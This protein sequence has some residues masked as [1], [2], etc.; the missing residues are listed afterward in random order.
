MASG[1][2][3]NKRG[4]DV[5]PEDVEIF[6]HFTASRTSSGDAELIQLDPNLV[7]IPTENPNNPSSVNTEIFGGLY[8]LKLPTTTFTDKG[9][10]TVIIKPKE[11]RTTIQSCG[12]L[13]AYP[14]VRGIVFDIDTISV[15]DRSVFFNNNLIGYRVEYINQTPINNERKKQNYFTIITSNNFGVFTHNNDADVIN[16]SQRFVFDDTSSLTFCTLT[17]SSSP[18]VRPNVLPEIGNPGQEVIITNT[19]FDPITI[20]IEMVDHDIETLAYA[21]YGNQT[22]SLEDGIYTVYN[23]DNQIYFQADLYEIKEE[24]NG[25]PL[26]EIREERSSIDFS[27]QFN[28][29]TT[30]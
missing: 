9:F 4:A 21:L 20:E 13:G 15:E 3:G 12:V 23:F 14:D 27:K 24:Y 7:L 11:I 8:T 26:Y 30:L 22:K 16:Q 19:F 18:N 1:V 10:Y 2:Y 6:V 17:P 29:I 5:G 25:T 28:N